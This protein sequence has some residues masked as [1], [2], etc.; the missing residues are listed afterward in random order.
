[1][2]ADT[3]MIL[4]GMHFLLDHQ[5]SGKQCKATG[6]AKTFPIRLKSLK[7]GKL[8]L[9]SKLISTAINPPSTIHN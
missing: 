5:Q 4:N 1:L 8:Q 7:L 9:F 3:A 6:I 2:I